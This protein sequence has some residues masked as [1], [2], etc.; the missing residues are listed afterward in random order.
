LFHGMGQNEKAPLITTRQRS[1]KNKKTALGGGTPR[2]E[3]MQRSRTSNHSPFA[4]FSISYRVR[5]C[6]HERRDRTLWRPFKSR[7]EDTRSP[8]P[9]AT[10]T[11]AS[12]SGS[13]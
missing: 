7:G 1:A 2:A 9:K 11:P 3:K 4:P 5:G 8:S 10:T 13:T 6:K 12:A